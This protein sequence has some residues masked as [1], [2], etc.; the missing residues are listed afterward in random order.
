MKKAAAIKNNVTTI[1]VFI[2]LRF[3]DEIDRQPRLHVVVAAA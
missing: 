3:D 1:V 2:P